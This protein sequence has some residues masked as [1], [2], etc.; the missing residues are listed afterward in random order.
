[1]SYRSNIDEA[2]RRMRKAQGRALTAIGVYVSG[3]AQLRAPRDTGNLASSLTYRV[4]GARGR[5]DIGTPVDYAIYPEKGTRY[6]D[7]QP[8]LTPAAEENVANIKRLA[9][10]EYRKGMSDG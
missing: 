10:D 8:Y 1:M 6:Q 2:K 5:V 3:E 4:E 7:A 9:A